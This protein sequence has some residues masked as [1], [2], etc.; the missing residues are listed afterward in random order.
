MR[1]PGTNRAAARLTAFFA[2]AISAVPAL[3]QPQGAFGSG[4]GTARGGA[5]FQSFSVTIN[6]NGQVFDSGQEEIEHYDP[7]VG[8]AAGGARV[9]ANLPG[10]LIGFSA[11]GLARTGGGVMDGGAIATVDFNSGYIVTSQTLAPGTIVQIELRVTTSKTRSIFHTNEVPTPQRS[12][13]SG[14]LY[15]EIDSTAPSNDRYRE[16]GLNSRSQ[17]DTEDNNSGSINGS[18][19]QNASIWSDGER[20]VVIDAVVGQQ[21]LF[22]IM[23]TARASVGVQFVDQRGRATFCGAI[24]FGMSPQQDFELVPFDQQ[25]VPPPVTTEILT[26][27]YVGI[28]TPPDPVQDCAID[29]DMD[30]FVNFLDVIAYLAL[31]D[32]GDLEADWNNNGVIDPNDLDLFLMNFEEGCVPYEIG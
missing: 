21:V 15:F 23:I 16:F 22:E 32:A 25:A 11:G 4:S 13:S 27:N 7:N 10:G 29:I 17:F 12:T 8:R 19:I 30:G 5:P 1:T 6:E 14:E 31:Y 28:F 3:A 9:S 24:G 2:A 26:P 20:T 18:P